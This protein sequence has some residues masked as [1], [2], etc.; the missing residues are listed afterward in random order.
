[1]KI[2]TAIL[3]AV[4]SVVILFT[5][6]K[7]AATVT[8]TDNG[9]GTVT[10]A[11]SLISIVVN[12]SN[13]SI[14]SILSSK[15]PGVN[16]LASGKS[17]GLELTHIGSG[18]Q[19]TPVNDYWTDV[20]AGGS[21]V[22]SV[23]ENSGTMVDIQ[24]RNPT[25]CPDLTTYPNGLWDWSIHHVMFDNDSGYY[26]YHVWR[27]TALQPESYWDA[28]SWQGYTNG[29]LF[30][31]SPISTA[32]DFCGLQKIGISCGAFPANADSEG[33]PGEVNILAMNGYFTQATGQYYEPNWQIYTQPTGL[34]YWL[35]PTWTKYDWPTYL[36]PTTSYRNTWGVADDFAGIWHCNASNE[37]R[38]GGP[39]KLSGA[40][41]GSYMYEDDDEGHGL[42]P[43]NTT[44]AAG[45]VYV[46]MIGPF[47]T[48]INTGTNHNQL[49]ADAQAK[50]A[51]EVAKWPYAWVNEPESDYNRIRGTV[52]GQM[53]TTTGQSTANAVVIL[54][55]PVSTTYPDWIW[56]GCINYLY[57]TTADANGNFT[58]PKVDPGT[59]TLYSY[60]PGVFSTGSNASGVT[61]AGPGLPTASNYGE[62]IQDNVVVTGSSTTSLGTIAW[63]PLRAQ[64]VLFQLGIPDHTTAEFRFGDL[65]KQFGLW[66]RYYNEVGSGVLNFNV[67]TSN[68]ANNWYYAQ[69]IFALPNGTYAEPPWNINFNL[70]AVPSTPVTLTV[71]IC[72]GYGTC[73]YTYVNGVNETPSPYQGTGIY[74][75]SGADIYRDVVQVGRWQRYVVTLP[76]SAFK[77]G[78]NTLQIGVRQGGFGGT[79][80]PAAGGYP[81]LVAGGLMYDAVKLEAGPNTTQMIQNGTFKV[82]SGLNGDVLRVQ[83]GSTTSGAAVVEYPFL[84]ENDEE[85]TFTDL[86]NDVYSIRAVNS[87]LALTVQNASTAINAPVVQSAYTGATSQQWNAVLN[88]SGGISLINQNS[89]LALDIPGQRS[90]YQDNVQ[91]IQ[92][93]PNNGLSQSWYETP[94]TYGPPPAPTGL[95][96]TPGNSQVS[97]A[98]NPSERA[99]S[100]AITR[101]TSS[102]GENVLLAANVTGTNYVDTTATN[103]VPYFYTATAWTNV[104]GWGA[105]PYSNEVAATPLPPLPAAPGN[106]FGIPESGQVMLTWIPSAYASTYTL[107][108]T[109]ASGG[110]STVFAALTGTTC[111]D[112]GLTN[113]RSYDYTVAGVN[114]S[115]TGSSSNI[116]TV[117]PT[118]YKPGVP[119]GLTA[120][121]GN[122]AIGL[123]WTP[124]TGAGAASYIILRGTTSGTYNTQI[125]VSSEYT[126][127]VDTPLTNGVAYYYAVEADN[128]IGISATSNQASA[129]PAFNPPAAPAGLVA[130]SGNQQ[131]TLAWKASTGATGYTLV[132]GTSSGIY[133]VTVAAGITGTNYTDTGLTNGSV[134]Y[135]AVSATSLGGTSGYST[136]A[137]G[138][139]SRSAGTITW[140][141]STNVNWDTST[142]NWQY[143]GG[144]ANFQAGDSLVFGDGVNPSAADLFLT[145]N[146]SMGGM[147][148]NTASVSYG[149]NGVGTISGTGGVTF[150]GSNTSL[151]IGVAM[152][153]TGPTLIQGGT[154]YLQSP[155][156]LGTGK[157]T[158]SNGTLAASSYGGVI[159]VGAN[160][161]AVATGQTGAIVTGASMSLGPV[162]G[163]GT[164]NITD[165]G[166]STA[167]KAENLCGTWG[168]TFTGTLNVSST[169]GIVLTGYY[170]GGNPDFDGNLT[171]ATVNLNNVGI[172]SWNSSGGNSV[173]FGALNGT[174]T[175]SIIGSA[176]AGGLTVSIGALNTN[177]VFA[178]AISNS[179]GGGNTTIVKTGTGSL[180]LSGSCS[181]AGPTNVTKGNLTVNGMLSGSG[182]QLT[183]S[184]G[185]SLSGTGGITGGV[186]V[187]SGASLLLS[188][189]GNL[190]LTGNLAFGGSVTVSS[191]TSTLLS[192]GTY[193]LLTYTGSETGTP[194]FT[195]VAQKG[196]KQTATFNNATAGVITVNLSGPPTAPTGLT[197]TPGNSQVALAWT[198]SPSA[199]GYIIERGTSSGGE[200]AITGGTTTAVS[201]TDSAVT[202]GL[203]YFY[204][205][206]A[207]NSL[208]TGGTSAEASTTVGLTYNQWT[209][210]SYP[211]VTDTNVIA[212]TA[213]PMND[214][215]ANLLKYFMGLNPAKQS[216]M[217]ISCAL[218]GQGNL[219]FQFPM[220]KGLT[221]VSYT[222]NECADL[223]TW[224]STGLQGTIK[225]DMG[226]YDTMQVTVPLPASGPLFLRLSVSSS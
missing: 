54:G 1:V 208:G 18:P 169:D 201:D 173:T 83:G 81:D 76:S 62:Y 219:V 32:W 162:T 225:A 171:N 181:Y 91:L 31:S 45:Q 48:Y 119:T 160:T 165:S 199:T 178:G 89:G 161:L 198:A 11:N 189:T 80:N 146:V 93:T 69:P 138:T 58:I 151:T 139:P 125:T 129:T 221:G 113:G 155:G 131:L 190:A 7:A 64:N 224:T 97:F 26:T 4:V 39:T 17:L 6:C 154:L 77:T 2:K 182:T 5:P 55:L 100:Y 21:E 216:S 111:T 193:T 14:S 98:W 37:W 218:D 172:S 67:G 179:A 177:S 140:M 78:S 215:I 200:V 145:T 214:G 106:L 12:K 47:Y 13:G 87:G 3:C 149:I 25:A 115:G 88:T 59:Y 202:N 20:S 44:V 222:I 16:F 40:M 70:A 114:I 66:F 29:T 191:A 35:Y 150:T 153:T 128:A 204:T 186:T 46:K 92:N 157:I 95:V 130:S 183:V 220:A 122:N 152:S 141:G 63:S 117:S 60:V 166:G 24:I 164:M 110:A 226:T 121:S 105:S 134:Y 205:V 79:W 50:G 49:W 127:Y 10:L 74:T 120:L 52:T 85:W 116:A 65:M 143:G 176:Y 211:G 192:P 109:P 90:D 61:V 102:G 144:S 19:A 118:P 207:T 23:V 101:G 213:T 57:W 73:F 108:R 9:N 51:Q 28:D 84:F 133:P 184:S 68:A 42:G 30:S 195:Y 22:Y 212:M 217:P 175:A 196:V 126:S 197:L 15:I 36:G 206:T 112:T 53:T 167:A 56:Q 33:V 43:T 203:T 147:T 34:T 94:Q 103:G 142:P 210:T 132:R 86:G 124:A 148:V 107:T 75:N 156:S 209:A 38:N 185:A 187:N 82:G 96:A 104:N 71:D 188:S 137:T 170:N 174:S 41:S 168:G 194:V 159:A 180:M 223:K 8:V 135:Y 99:V 163:G 158:F 123:T 136:Q 27:H 72:G